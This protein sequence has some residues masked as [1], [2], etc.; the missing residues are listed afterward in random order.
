[1]SLVRL[2]TAGKSLIGLQAPKTRYH[3]HTQRPF[4]QFGSNRNP[5]R[6]TTRPEQ[7]P[8]ASG[9]SFQQPPLT[10]TLSPSPGERGN[11]PPPVPKI[12]TDNERT[13]KSSDLLPNSSTTEIK[14]NISPAPNIQV[15]KP[16]PVSR[17]GEWFGWRRS[18]A[19]RALGKLSQKALV[20]GELSLDRVRVVRN[21]LTDSDLEVVSV[22]RA[23]KPQSAA[24]MEGAASSASMRASEAAEGLAGARLAARA[25]SRMAGRLM[26]AGKS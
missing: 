3:L 8:A 18:R 26:G 17:L 14:G 5:F 7:A 21:D 25:W 24:S 13:G 10:P 6:T 16:R 4:P 9:S 12:Q 15:P 23:A 1:M 2:L 19:T 11:N 20:Q 22:R